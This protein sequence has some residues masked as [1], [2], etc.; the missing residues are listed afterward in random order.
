MIVFGDWSVQSLCLM[1]GRILSNMGK[2]SQKAQAPVCLNN[3]K[4]FPLENSYPV[5]KN[6]E[7][8]KLL[9]LLFRGLA[10]G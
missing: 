5:D 4:H 7:N 9:N 8:P 3:K 10:R 6:D 1:A 2:F